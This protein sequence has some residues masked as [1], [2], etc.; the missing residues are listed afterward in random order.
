MDPLLYN[1]LWIFGWV[2]VVMAVWLV[3]SGRR[4]RR[5]E[6]IHAERMAAIEKASL[7]RSSPTTRH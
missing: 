3:R 1:L 4:Q 6:I 7:C 5:I 2:L